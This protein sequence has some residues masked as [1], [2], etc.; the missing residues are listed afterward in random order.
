M[1]STVHKYRYIVRQTLFRAMM[2]FLTD[3]QYQDVM[4]VAGM[5][6]YIDMEVTPQG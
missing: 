5:M 6:P 2:R 3:E 4:L 1:Y